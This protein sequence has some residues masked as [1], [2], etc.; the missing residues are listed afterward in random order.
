MGFDPHSLTIVLVSLHDWMFHGADK[1]ELIVVV[2]PIL[3][4]AFT[5]RPG[6]VLRTLDI[7][8]ECDTLPFNFLLVEGFL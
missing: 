4:T 3:S 1:F 5:G 7:I 8:S 6:T 2:A